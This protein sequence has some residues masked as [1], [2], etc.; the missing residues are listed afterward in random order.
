VLYDQFDH[1]SLNLA[2]SQQFEPAFNQYDDETAD[3]FTVPAGQTWL[4]DQVEVAGSYSTSGHADSVNVVFY[5]GGGTLPGAPVVSL[6]DRIPSSGLDTGSFV[7]PLNPPVMLTPGTYWLSVQ[8]HQRYDPNGQ[9]FWRNQSQPGNGNPAAWRNPND[10]FARCANWNPRNACGI[11]GYLDPDQIFRLYGLNN[12]TPTPTPTGTPA[13]A[14]RTGTRTPLPPSPPGSPILPPPVVTQSAPLTPAPATVDPTPIPSCAVQW[15][16]VPAPTAGPGSTTTLQSVAAV[17]ATDVWAVG[18]DYGSTTQ[19][20]IVHWDGQGWQRVPS[21]NVPDAGNYLEGVDAVAANDVWAVGTYYDSFN[22]TNAPLILHWNGTSWSVVPGPTLS[23]SAQLRDVAARAADDVW[24]VGS[25]NTDGPLIVHWNGTTWV[26]VPPPPGTGNGSLE[27]VTALAPNDAWAVGIRY[28]SFNIHTFTI[29]WDGSA[30]IEVSSPSPGWEAWLVSVTA[31]A[32]NDVWAVGYQYADNMNRYYRTLIEHWDGT[33]WSVVAS[34]NPGFQNDWLFDVAALGPTDV[35]AVGYQVGGT[36]YP[37]TLAI[38]WNGTAWN[39]VPSPN[40]STAYN[41]LFGIDGVSATDLWA[42]G[43]SGYETQQPL[44]EHYADPCAPPLPTNTPV[45]TATPTATETSTA[46]ATSTVTE[47]S[48]ATATPPVTATPTACPIQFEDVPVGSTFYDFIRCLACRGIVGGYPCG[49]PGEPCPGAYYRP[50]NNVT[51]GQVS[52]IVSESAGFT[53]AVPST[54]QTFE[55]VPPSGTFW[56]W[57]ERLS[58]RG[59]IGGYPCGGPFEPCVS[60]TNRPYFRPNNN[61]TRGQLSKIVAGA[62]GWTETPTGQTF[63][64]VPPTGT[65]Y[66]YVERLSS[67]GIIGGYP[68]GGPFEPCVGPANRPYFRPNNN[69][70]RGQMAKIAAQAFFPN[71]Q[72][73]QASNRR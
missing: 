37:G 7:I 28:S 32:T 15:R 6:P 5:A 35:W 8:A 64:D 70:T 14:T 36:G 51:R 20:L 50:N 61:V 19:T 22:F 3:D 1:Q 60:P 71:C 40:G 45:P 18:T 43:H 63:E 67:R 29:H 53:D 46:T 38:H 59:I 56:L 16:V 44:I 26:Q 2:G 13:T 30:W 17:S 9:W 42:V 21:P 34:P 24:A 72:T 49:G 62:A 73:P 55:D 54:Q 23:G 25:S 10:G 68:C 48:T 57:V 39:E 58:S 4:I 12:V 33:T 69:A 66:L 11:S 52:K 65:F 47:T 41:Y 31:V 27:A